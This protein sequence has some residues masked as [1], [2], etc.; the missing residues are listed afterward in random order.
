MTPNLGWTNTKPCSYTYS[1][2]K[3]GQ[4]KFKRTATKTLVSFT[5]KLQ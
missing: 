3:K 5:M 1:E 4:N 2:P